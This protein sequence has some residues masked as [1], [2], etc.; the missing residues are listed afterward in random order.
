MSKFDRKAQQLK[1]RV[2]FVRGTVRKGKGATLSDEEADTMTDDQV[3]DEITLG[4]LEAVDREA[5][6]PEAPAGGE[7][8]AGDKAG[9]PPATGGRKAANK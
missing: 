7:G 3:A 5:E 6:A 2:Q 9:D 8:E 4:N 1:A